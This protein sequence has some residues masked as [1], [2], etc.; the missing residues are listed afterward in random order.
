MVREP[1]RVGHIPDDQKHLSQW[2]TAYLFCFIWFWNENGKN[3]GL[4][5]QGLSSTI[6]DEVMFGKEISKSIKC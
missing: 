5:C 6:A 4:R 2:G 1:L 3:Q